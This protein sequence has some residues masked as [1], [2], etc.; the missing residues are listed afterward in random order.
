M[1]SYANGGHNQSMAA[2]LQAHSR[3]RADGKEKKGVKKKKS[4]WSG[5]EQRTASA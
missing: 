2:R 1:S 4:G 5:A 3:E